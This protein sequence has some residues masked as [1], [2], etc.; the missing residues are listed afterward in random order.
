MA[1]AGATFLAST[2][3]AQP[4]IVG[5]PSGQILAAGDRRVMVLSPA[6]EVLWDYPT[7]LTH[8]VWMLPSG[9][10]L[11][12]DGDTVTE[13]TRDKQVVFQYRAAEQKGGGT[14]ACQRLPDGK[15]FVG[16]NSTGRLLEL[17]TAGKVVFSLQTSPYQAGQHH[18]MRM[19]RKLGSGNYLVCHSG[20]RRVKEYTPKGEVVWEVKVPGSLAFAAIRTPS[21]S[22]LVSCLD[23]VVEYDP[24][25]KTIWEFRTEDLAPAVTLR[26][27]TGINLLSNGN[28]LAGCYQAYA[29]GRGCGLLEISRDKRVVWNYSKPNE[30]QTM[31]AVQLLSAEGKPLPGDV[32]R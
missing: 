27:L 30:D 26:N 28:V 1:L 6:G 17:D 18:N 24:S 2:L 4:A 20:A 16:E 9:N 32:L 31:M 29:N 10:V 7:K 15:T 12:A 13:V 14:Y 3:A 8:D 23:R 11:F 19:A 25:G 21:G 22:T 5:Q